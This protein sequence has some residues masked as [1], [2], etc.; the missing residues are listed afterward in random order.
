MSNLGAVNVDGIGGIDHHSEFIT[1]FTTRGSYES[2]IETIG[3]WLTGRREVALCSAVGAW[4]EVEDDTI[5]NSSSGSVGIES[6]AAFA[7]V[8]VMRSCTSSGG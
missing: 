7:N 6:E 5:T 4:E 3:Q 8:D 2:G 1:C